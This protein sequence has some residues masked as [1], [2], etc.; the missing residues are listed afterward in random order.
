MVN[1]ISAGV[2]LVGIITPYLSVRSL[3]EIKV[4]VINE[5]HFNISWLYID[6]VHILLNI[7]KI[8]H[9]QFTGWA[10]GEQK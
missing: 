8:F 7:D 1:R 9:E 5:I 2:F 10:S 6:S 4:N 3:R